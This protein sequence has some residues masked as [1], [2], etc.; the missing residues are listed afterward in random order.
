M[1]EQGNLP[2][3]EGDIP[4]GTVGVA[5]ASFNGE[6]VSRLFE[7]FKSYFGAH[8]GPLALE[9]IHVPGSLELAHGLR[10]LGERHKDI[11]SLVALGCVIKGSTFHFEV[12]SL[13][14]CQ[15]ISR[16]SELTGVPV[17]NG[18]LTCYDEA[19]AIERAASNGKSFANAAIKM[20]QIGPV[21]KRCCD[22]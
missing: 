4:E 8:G 18:I 20:A 15:S 9:V 13:Q 11:R 1:A 10:V 17:V 2:P 14:S 12:V 22:G 5:I 21:A 19:Q 6:L 16:V 7:D 3:L